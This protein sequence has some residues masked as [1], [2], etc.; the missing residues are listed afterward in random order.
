VLDE[1]LLSPLPQLNHPDELMK[2]RRRNAPEL[3]GRR[4]QEKLRS[5]VDVLE[6]QEFFRAYFQTSRLGICVGFA[7]KRMC[8]EVV[9]CLEL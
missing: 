3:F 6:H 1:Q 8:A 5:S 4:Q 7:L 2:A 9:R